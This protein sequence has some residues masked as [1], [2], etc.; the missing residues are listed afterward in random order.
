MI[1]N[2][3]NFSVWQR[4]LIFFSIL[5]GILLALV[6]VTLL[7]INQTLNSG[8]RV[9]AVPL[10]AQTTVQQF[11]ALPDDNAYPSSVALA[12]DGTVYT[13]SFATG[14]IWAI[15]PSGTV[16]EVP[17]T[18]DGIGAAMGLAVAPDGS[19][20]VVDQLDTDPRSS[21]GKVVRVVD[22]KVATFTT[23]KFVS[24]LDVTLDGAGHVYVSDS[25]TNQVWRFDAD[26]S[27][28]AVWWT[29]PA[30]ASGSTHPAAT[31]LA[32]DTVHDA[33]I[34]TDPESNT[35]YRVNV[36]DAATETLYDHD[37]QPNAPGFDGVTVTPDGTIY[38]AA[39]AQ[40][41]I[42]KVADGKLEYIAGMF[43]GPSDV[44]FAAPN[45]L[46]VTNFDQTSIV[47]PVVHPQ[48]PFAL[49]VVELGS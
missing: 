47:I 43:R 23:E 21:G 32:Y 13:G 1:R 41:G 37:G 26:G 24:P 22:G 11:A 20:L 48:L 10:N 4:R 16:T 14:A 49:D 33:I 30:Q 12:A 40:N 17:G 25:G 5:G 18:R 28:G 8:L 45:R 15:S 36:S 9:T 42:A 27:N 2:L 6:A 39:L 3:Q 34:V 7:L 44:A 29:S 31:G 35:I 38:V 19:L 46:Y